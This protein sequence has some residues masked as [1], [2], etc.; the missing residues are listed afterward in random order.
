MTSVG[1]LASESIREE[2]PAE[3]ALTPVGLGVSS[4]SLRGF[5]SALDAGERAHLFSL[6]L[7]NPKGLQDYFMI[8]ED[9]ISTRISRAVCVLYNNV[10]LLLRHQTEGD[11][12]TWISSSGTK[13]LDQ[14]SEMLFIYGYLYPRHILSVSPTRVGKGIYS[15]YR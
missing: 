12:A 10:F 8:T 3:I 14:N 4:L 9:R 6:N 2:V 7:G 1:W 13:Q 15:R 11:L 5:Y